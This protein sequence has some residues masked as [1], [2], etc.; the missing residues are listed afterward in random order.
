[1]RPARLS[2]T[3]M[4]RLV[5]RSGGLTEDEWFGEVKRVLKSRHVQVIAVGVTELVGISAGEL[6]NPGKATFKDIRHT[7]WRIM[8]FFILWVMVIGFIGRMRICWELRLRRSTRLL[9]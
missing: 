6:A 2:T 7:S 1:M 8:L 4:I 3:T 9:L 5:H